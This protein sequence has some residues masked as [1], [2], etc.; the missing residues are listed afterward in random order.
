MDCINKNLIKLKLFPLECFDIRYPECSTDRLSFDLPPDI[1][2]DLL[3]YRYKLVPY[4]G[5]IE[6]K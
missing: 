3:D 4:D 6:V 5:R 1:L 2:R